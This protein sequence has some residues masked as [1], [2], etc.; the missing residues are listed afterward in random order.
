MARRVR[1]QSR[2]GKPS[3]RPADERE[4]IGRVTRLLREAQRLQQ[5]AAAPVVGL[6]IPVRRDH[7][8]AVRCHSFR[9]WP[10]RG[11][12]VALHAVPDQYGRVG[13]VTE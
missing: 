4:A 1:G 6:R 12:G 7:R 9:E 5:I 11:S 8:Q 3:H 2:R 13:R 10:H